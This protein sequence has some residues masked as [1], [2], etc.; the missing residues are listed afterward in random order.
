MGIPSFRRGRRRQD[1]QALVEFSLTAIAF[2]FLLVMIIEVGRIFGAYVLL[3]HAT[4]AGARY[5]VTGQWY[6]KYADNPQAGWTS[7]SDDPLQQIPPCWPRFYDESTYNGVGEDAN[8]ADAF[9]YY[10]PYRNARTCS[11]EEVV[12]RTI[13]SMVPLNPSAEPGEEGY[14]MLRVSGATDDKYPN[15]GTFT[16]S[17]STEYNYAAY[18][19]LT[20][21]DGDNAGLSPGFAGVPQEKVVVQMNY[22]L[23]LITPLMRNIAPSIMLRGTAVMTN[24]P[25]GSTSLQREAILP[26]ELVGLSELAPATEKDLDVTSVSLVGGAVDPLLPDG[27]ADFDV[28]VA[29]LGQIIIREYFDVKLYASLDPISGT[30][31]GPDVT[32]VGSATVTGLNGESATTVSYHLDYASF[33]GAGTYYLYA[34][35]DAGEIVSEA[36]ED[37]N[38]GMYSPVQVGEYDDLSLDK[39]ASAPEVGDGDQVTY[40]LTVANSEYG[41]ERS[42]VVVIDQ[43]PPGATYVSDSSGGAYDPDTGVWTVGT[44]APD[45]SSQLTITA[46]LNGAGGELITNSAALSLT[47]P[48]DDPG[49]DSASVGVTISYPE[50]DLAIEKVASATEVDNGEQVTYTLTASNLGGI[51]ATSVVV[52]DLLPTGA[53][54]DSHSGG[55]YDPSSGVWTVGDLA[56]G[57]S[58]QLTIITTLTGEN[59][60]V[61]TNTATIAADQPDPESL[62]DSS[63]ADVTVISAVDVSLEASA[64]YVGRSG[65]YWTYDNYELT[66]TARNN[67]TSDASGVTVTINRSSANVQFDYDVSGDCSSN[68]GTFCDFGTIP[69]GETRQLVYRVRIPTYYA[70]SS[71]NVDFTLNTDDENSSTETHHLVTL[72]TA[73]AST[74]LSLSKSVSVD[75]V[76]NDGEVTYTLTV[77][78]PSDGFDATNVVVTDVLPGAAAY[79]S[80]SGPGNYNVSAGIWTVGNL[81]A[82]DSASLHITATL[83]GS[84][85]AIITNT[86]TVAADQ[87]DPNLANNVAS[88][89]VTIIEISN[90]NVSL[91][92]FSSYVDYRWG[93]YY[94]RITVRAHNEGSTDANG[95]SVDIS[96]SSGGVS[97]NNTSTDQSDCDYHGGPTCDFGTVRAGDTEQLV[98]WV[99]IGWWVDGSQYAYF[100]LNTDEPNVNPDIHETERIR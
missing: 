42:D 70:G 89:S 41:I 73:L 34:W 63:S 6:Q 28:E 1:G 96:Y 83:S 95:V 44:L 8:T 51:D 5:A 26:P 58:V 36:D 72:S 53:A 100:T 93:R 4:R 2:L 40:T 52:T 77:S 33:P 91:S 69:A 62:N 75:E 90:V 39:I 25:Y 87:I 68:G 61:I 81:D 97:Y 9:D 18:F 59:E 31:T 32:E 94:Y 16:R 22:R 21:F 56:S 23:P 7:G 76:G 92:A 78:N 46:V 88:V 99:S 84:I 49:N 27:T 10:E 71:Y 65:Y 85:G 20:E 12:L 79:I 64:E 48:D 47:E 66:V 55:D 38:V 67:G 24:E 29:N 74:D 19:P 14:Y 17:S 11:V 80:H 54:Y 37:N 30:P 57:A 98:Y 60:E 86:A 43:L 35:A 82:G 50:T 3:Q 15:T 13:T 45:T